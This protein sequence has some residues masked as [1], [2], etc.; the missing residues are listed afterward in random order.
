VL[1]GILE[2]NKVS[3]R[4]PDQDQQYLLHDGW[5]GGAVVSSELGRAGWRLG[6]P[7][8]RTPVFELE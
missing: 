3:D 4:D 8:E 1:A 2:A 7:Q 6:P 5:R